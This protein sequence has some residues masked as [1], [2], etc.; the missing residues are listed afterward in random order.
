[1]A[2]IKAT[3]RSDPFLNDPLNAGEL[4]EAV[5]R[6]IRVWSHLE[7]HFNSNL[8]VMLGHRAVAPLRN[9]LKLDEDG[10]VSF[11]RKLKHWRRLWSNIPEFARFKTGALQFADQI[12]DANKDRN[13]LLHNAWQ[14]FTNH[15]T[16]T[17][18]SA[19]WA[20]RSGKLITATTS[21]GVAD[22]RN[23]MQTADAL[24]TRLLMFTFVLA[25][26]SRPIEAA[27]TPPPPETPR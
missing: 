9:E 20:L 22:V 15:D 26:T 2:S 19:S 4:Y 8:I 14:E 27:G 11:K 13:T 16:L 21:F 1:M 17:V 24:N 7:E 3:L 23:M 6:Y 10:P 25:K 5:G 18:K 12:G